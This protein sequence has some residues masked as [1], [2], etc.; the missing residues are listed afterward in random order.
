MSKMTP[1][2]LE[3]TPV[4][5]QEMD[6]LEL[7]LLDDGTPFLSGRSLARIAGVV[8]SVVNEWAN[9]YNPNASKGRDRIIAGL[10]AKSGFSGDA[11]FVKVKLGTGPAVN[12]YPDAVVMAVLEYYGFEHEK[13]SETAQQAFRTLGRAGFRTFAYTALGIDP[14]KRSPDAFKSYHQRLLLNPMPSGFFCV[15]TETDHLLLASIREGLPVD[16]HTVP[17]ISIGQAWS[18]EWTLRAYDDRFGPRTKY[19]HKYPDDYPQARASPDAF[20]YP[21]GGLGEFRVWLDAHYLPKKYPD[22]IKRKVK[23]GTLPASRAE[24]LLAAVVPKQIESGDE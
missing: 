9:E 3:L 2:Q 23:L 8:P 1:K 5:Y 7:G 20:I 10:L 15:L 14:T 19:P 24:L 6:G 17:D 22:Y 16:Q 13:K 12:A 21:L 11:L 4:A 18:A